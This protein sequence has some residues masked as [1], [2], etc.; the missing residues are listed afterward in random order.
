MPAHS[1]GFYLSVEMRIED[2]NKRNS[3][4]VVAARLLVNRQATSMLDDKARKCRPSTDRMHFLSKITEVT[5]AVCGLTARGKA[6]G[7]QATE[8]NAKEVFRGKARQLGIAFQE[9]KDEM[10][11]MPQAGHDEHGRFADE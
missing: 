11:Q 1:D 8:G 6:D 4:A 5:I 2:A 9:E 3:P 7:I 10:S